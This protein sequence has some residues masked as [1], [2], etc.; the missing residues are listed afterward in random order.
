MKLYNSSQFIDLLTCSGSFQESKQF[1]KLND[2]S[3]FL[4]LLDYS[5]QLS[6]YIHWQK[7]NEYLLLIYT[8]S[9]S[10]IDFNEFIVKFIQ[11]WEKNEKIVLSLQKN[12][13]LLENFDINQK[14][15]GFSALISNLSVEC[16][17]VE[18]NQTPQNVKYFLRFIGSCQS[19]IETFN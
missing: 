2:R 12:P 9:N 13:K 4:Q 15:S 18:S 17:V 14:S 16:D 5:V 10:I 3:K 7:R 1:L 6:D 19:E 8:L 11:L